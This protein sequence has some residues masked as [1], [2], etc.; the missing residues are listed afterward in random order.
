MFISSWPIDEPSC[1][2]PWVPGRLPTCPPTHSHTYTPTHTRTHAHTTHPFAPTL[3][4]ERPPP[5]PPAGHQLA[6]PAVERGQQ[7][8]A[9]GRARPG[10]ERL[11]AGFPAG[12]ARRLC[13][14]GPGAAGGTR[15]QPALL[16]RCAV[17]WAEL[18][19]VRA[20]LAS[21]ASIAGVKRVLAAPTPPAASP[22]PSVGAPR[23]RPRLPC[24]PAGEFAYWLGPSVDV[25]PYYGPVAAR[26]VMHD[27]ELWLHPSSLEGRGLP[28]PALT[29]RVSAA[30]GGE[31]VQLP[32][33]RTPWQG[34]RCLCQVG[35]IWQL[36]WRAGGPRCMLTGCGWSP[37]IN[38]TWPGLLQRVAAASAVH[39]CARAL[40]PALP[41]PPAGAQARR[42]ADLVRGLHRRRRRA[43]GHH[44]GGGGAG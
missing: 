39:A 32:L 29:D 35:R 11:G 18:A 1:P 16:G 26:A 34:R 12:P 24:R 38:Q 30:A 13:V 31:A 15:G 5:R 28:R 19:D 40:L 4:L 41:A 27:H 43:Q 21:V 14:P 10:Q 2:A 22:S 7:R 23:Q 6:A 8:G 36:R 25:L 9:G 17:A 33:R 3:I 37:R 44:L 42:R 20:V